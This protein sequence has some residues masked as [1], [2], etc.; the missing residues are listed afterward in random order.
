MRR[1]IVLLLAALLLIPGGAY[2]AKDKTDLIDAEVTRVVDGDT[3]KVQIGKKEETIRLLLVDTPETKDPNKPVQPFG[4][5]ATAYAV[6]NLDGK[7][8]KLELDVSERDRYGRLLVYLWIGDKLFNEMLLKNGLARVAVYQPNVK[9][10]DQFRAVQ[11]TAQKAGINIWSLENYVQDD[12]FQS[13]EK[14]A[15]KP[16]AV[17]KTQPPAGKNAYYKNCTAVR[18]AGAAPLYKGD[19]GYSTKLDRDQDGVACEK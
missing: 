18:E 12:G 1:I 14:E 3:M 11:K 7:S 6:K 9:Y 4:K 2:A 8:V 13:P 15:K 19:P 5:E 17:K 10:V 16:A